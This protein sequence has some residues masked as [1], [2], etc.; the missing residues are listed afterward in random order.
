MVCVRKD[1]LAR[2]APKWL[3]PYLLSL[4]VSCIRTIVGVVCIVLHCI[5]WVVSS[6]LWVVSNM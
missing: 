4:D 6:G 3:V 5:V 2:Q 1:C